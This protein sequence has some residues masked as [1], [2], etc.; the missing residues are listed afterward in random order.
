M[1][2]QE[3]VAAVAASFS[4]VEYRFMSWAQLNVEMDHV[5]RPTIVYILPPSGELTP[6]R[7][8]ALWKDAPQ[9]LFA[10]LTPTDFDFDGVLNDEKIEIMKNLAKQF[11]KA[12]NESGE[13]E[14]ID[15]DALPYQVAYDVLDDNLTGIVL[16]TPLRE[17]VGT[18]LCEI[19]YNFGNH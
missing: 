18:P 16:T 10:F 7:S 6:T 8:A 17:R 14:M 13:F 9:T 11:I 2:I 1:T 12:L 19:D 5:D 15:G 4:G 3:K